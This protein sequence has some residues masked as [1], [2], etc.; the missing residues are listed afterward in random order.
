MAA[1]EAPAMT[2]RTATHRALY[3]PDGFFVRHAPAEHFRTSVTASPLFAAAIARLAQRVDDALGCPDRLA[4]VDIGAGR[5][6]LLLHLAAALPGPVRERTRFT[7]VE[8]APRPDGTPDWIHWTAKPPDQ[9]LGLLIATEWLDNVPVDVAEVDRAGEPRLVL[10]DPRTGAERLGDPP[11]GSDRAWLER[12]WPLGSEPGERAEIGHPRDTA[13]A[14]AV[15]TVRRGLAIAVDYGHLASDR[16]VHGTLTGYR[17]GRQMTP[18][19]DGSRDVTAHVAIDAVAAAGAA[20]A[21][22]GPTLLTQRE[23]LRALGVTGRRPALTM[24][25]TDPAGYLRALAQASEAAELTT[26]DGLGG[27]FWIRQPVGMTLDVVG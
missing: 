14:A 13:W 10:V 5:G 18:V 22:T 7:A 9:V 19:P 8:L 4:I 2:W 12:W 15:G 20:V 26:R 27:H 6:E 23:A 25:T 17:D 3:G 24:A 21:G 16:P 1:T 11:T